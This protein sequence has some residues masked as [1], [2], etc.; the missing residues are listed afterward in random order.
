M[1]DVHVHEYQQYEAYHFCE[2]GDDFAER[3]ERL[4]DVGALLQS[5][6]L[7]AR[8]VGALRPRQ[9]H[10]ADLRHLPVTANTSRY[11]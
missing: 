8:R 10:K 5:R 4:V 2:G 3:G 6:A 7:G 1:Y 11:K 9:V